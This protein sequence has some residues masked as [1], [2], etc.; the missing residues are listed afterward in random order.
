MLDRKS[1]PKFHRINKINIQGADFTAL[2]NQ[3]PV[4]T[5]S[6]GK[7]PVV[8]IELIFKAGSWFEKVP[9]TSYFATKMLSEGTHRLSS[10]QISNEIEKFG[11]HLDLTSTLDYVVIT[12]ESL[13]KHLA[14]LLPLLFELINN[15]SFPEDEFKTLKNIKA[16]QIRVSKEKTNILASVKFR[17]N[18]FGKHHPYGKDLSVKDVENLHM[19][20]VKEFY[21]RYFKGDFEIIVSGKPSAD[22]FSLLNESFG[23]N[24]IS[25]KGAFDTLQVIDA[26]S[27]KITIVEKKKNI[28][29]SIRLGKKLFKKNHPD[30]ID[31]LV[32]N[33]ILGGYFGSRLMKNI[34]E[35]KGYTYGISS[36]LI[37]LKNE[38]FFIIGTD[39][40]KENTQD[41]IN[42]IFREIE[43][44]QNS[45]VPEQELENVKNYMIGSFLSDINTP[46]ALSDKFKS[47]HL[48]GMDYSYY[49]KYIERINNI[50]AEEIKNIAIKYLD[51]ET[52]STVVV[53]GV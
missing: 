33:E 6:A 40:N 49:D 36:S 9:G 45:L 35:D 31:V 20:D 42:E 50:T 46:F 5:I 32:L 14:N 11:G 16:Q 37:T 1:P 15:P 25:K 47:V 21:N 10:A 7:Q 28:Q 41:T 17:E 24:S 29:S 48:N 4:Y 2:D 43:I 23:K 26:S 8:R 34:R 44:L 22:T 3:I 30:I 27:E 39:V 13:T 38:G 53:G 18:L 52:I 19:S 12:L 51:K